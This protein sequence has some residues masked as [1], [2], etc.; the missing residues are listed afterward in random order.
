MNVRN[1]HNMN[2]LQHYYN[3]KTRGESR[4]KNVFMNISYFIQRF[5]TGNNWIFLHFHYRIEKND[6]RKTKEG[7]MIYGQERNHFTC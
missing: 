7:I 2:E 4:K 5:F 1:A 6:E 3:M